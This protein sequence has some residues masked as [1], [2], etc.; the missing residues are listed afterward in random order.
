MHTPTYKFDEY[1]SKLRNIFFYQR[2]AQ[3]KHMGAFAVS[4]S[5]QCQNIDHYLLIIPKISY[6]IEEKEMRREN[7]FDEDIIQGV[8]K[9]VASF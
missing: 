1:N 8:P 9:N 6:K 5:A 2:F 7:H 3:H 4:S